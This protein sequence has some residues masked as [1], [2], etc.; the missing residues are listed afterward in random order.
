MFK[1]YWRDGW[2]KVGDSIIWQALQ[3]RKKIFLNQL[4]ALLQQQ[5]QWMHS[6]VVLMEKHNQ[7]LLS[8]AVTLSRQD[9]VREGGK[10]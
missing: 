5:T 6:E 9:K 1:N 10:P 3:D 8:E 4:S 2:E 7:L